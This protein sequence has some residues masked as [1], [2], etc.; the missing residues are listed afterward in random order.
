[1]RRVSSRPK[2][3]PLRFKPLDDELKQLIRERILR[4]RTT[5][6]MQTRSKAIANAMFSEGQKL[7]RFVD[8]EKLNNF[9]LTSSDIAAAIRAQNAQV[10]AGQIGGLPASPARCS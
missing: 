9:G 6:A 7:T 4:D 5:K 3:S 10:S 1:M 2:A 8:P